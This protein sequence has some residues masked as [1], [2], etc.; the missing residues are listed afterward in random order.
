MTNKTPVRI[1]F[2]CLGNICRSPLAEG[3][4]QKKIEEREF[5]DKIEI[6]SAGTGAWHI[7]EKPDRRMRQAASRHGV[8]LDHLRGRQA[9]ADDLTNFDLI[10]AM[11][12]SN[13]ETLRSWDSEHSANR[14]IRMFREFDPIPESLDV[15]DPYWL[16]SDGF[17]EVYQIVDRTCDALLEWVVGTYKLS[18]S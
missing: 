12:S 11:D 17:E 8:S 3:L 6:D 2:V 15:P 14:K 1:L 4:F 7:D 5:A 16:G 9:D 13:R 10:L 18:V